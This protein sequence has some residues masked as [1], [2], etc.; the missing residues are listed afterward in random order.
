MYRIATTKHISYVLCIFLII[1]SVSTVYVPKC[2]DSR[3]ICYIM[4]IYTNA[5]RF[6]SY[7]KQTLENDSDSDIQWIK[8]SADVYRQAVQERLVPLLVPVADIGIYTTVMQRNIRSCG[9]N[10]GR[11]YHMLN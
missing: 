2:P 7:N 8:E 4:P 5:Y 1:M 11:I 3:G 9:Y 10:K 6:T